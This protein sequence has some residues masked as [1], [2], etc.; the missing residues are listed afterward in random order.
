VVRDSQLLAWLRR[1]KRQLGPSEVRKIPGAA[2]LAR[3]W[4]RKPTVTGDT[5]ALQRQFNTLRLLVDQSRR[6]R[7]AWV[8]SI[9]AAGFL[10][11]ANGGQV[12]TAVLNSLGGR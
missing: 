1:C 2:V 8:L 4:H 12:L 11:L 7:A 6:R 10:M 9:P 3:N 5:D